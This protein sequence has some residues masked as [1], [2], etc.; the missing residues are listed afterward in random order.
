MPAKRQASDPIP[1]GVARE[2]AIRALALE[3]AP[4]VAPAANAAWSAS[5][6]V[7]EGLRRRSPGRL[8]EAERAFADAAL[9]HS[10]PNVRATALLVHAVHE[11]PLEADLG[12]LAEETLPALR[13]AFARALTATP[14]AAA[15]AALFALTADPHTNVAR[16]AR[17]QL[18]A[19]PRPGSASLEAQRVLLVDGPQLAP[20]VFFAVLDL[21]ER[22]PSNPQLVEAWHVRLRERASATGSEEDRARLGL[23]ATLPGLQAEGDV[24]AGWGLPLAGEGS[25]G[26]RARTARLERY[27]DR[28]PGSPLRAEQLLTRAR[29]IWEA[30]AEDDI[31]ARWEATELL[32][33][34]VQSHASAPLA[35]TDAE[36]PAEYAY[37]LG[38]DAAFSIAFWEATADQERP[39]DREARRALAH[40]DGE[41]REAAVEAV[42]RAYV[43]GSD[44]E[45]R[46]QEGSAAT[47]GARSRAL[48]DAQRFLIDVLEDP[49]L[50]SGAYAALVRPEAPLPRRVHAA[51][52]EWDID[53][54][55]R[56]LD[57]HAPDYPRPA[58]R[59]DLIHL[60]ANGAGRT[61]SVIERLGDF[62]GD[63]AAAG[64][65]RGWIYEELVGLAARRMPPESERRGPWRDS[66][67]RAIAL[68]RAWLRVRQDQRVSRELNLLHD[69]QEYGKELGKLLVAETLER[70]GGPE[71]L[72]EA[73]REEG[74]HLHVARRMRFEIVLL[75]E[76]ITAGEGGEPA[77]PLTLDDERRLLSELFVAYDGFDEELQLRVLRRAA[78]LDLELARARLVEVA[79]DGEA[80][81][82]LRRA[83]VE[84]L[85]TAGL[86][87]VV[88]PLLTRVS[89]EVAA[90]SD[91]DLR[92][93]VIR[94]LGECTPAVAN[95]ELA[96]LYADEEQRALF[97]DVLL[98]AMVRTELRAPSEVTGFE[99]WRFW[100]GEPSAAARRE[101]EARFVGERLPARDFAY[102]G[103]FEAARALAQ[104]GEL[105]AWLRGAWWTFDGRLLARL[106]EVV[107]DV[108][109]PDAPRL[110]RFIDRAARVA[111][112]GE[113]EAP[114]RDALLVRQRARLLWAAGEA[115]DLQLA[116][117]WARRQLDE[118]NGGRVSDLAWRSTYDGER[119]GPGE[120]APRRLLTLAAERP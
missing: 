83:A 118:W 38:W 17:L 61:A 84:S 82:V 99:V 56:G 64:A 48:A 16:E 53:T 115:G 26:R 78:G 34:S 7:L 47:N 25:Q 111:L 68:L 44:P 101:L 73:L 54:R 36:R 9:V 92:R 3:R 66:E 6:D 22:L 98:P 10:H 77:A 28:E 50:G 103:W 55:L 29:T 90:V 110:A 43:V 32:R 2:F 31:D 96:A 35:A 21:L 13:V 79:L 114:D 80:A 74:M 65:L 33:L 116:G 109:G 24:L 89:R 75:D 104:A 45:R 69:V 97:L 12:V 59:D 100:I 108:G 5:Y 62:R 15:E 1:D 46:R 67:S 57:E 8:S 11:L 52:R 86:P 63:D 70:D 105:E 19:R 112:E 41:V 81:E 106:A 39:F 20:G 94:A 37:D 4:F 23:V 119:L 107:R 72:R 76:G 42:G 60:W 93:A 58:W 18:L 113:G 91:H 30:A 27:V 71:A 120:L 49:V 40:V 87:E 117:R 14:G 85:A 88:T 95:S 102:A 51:W